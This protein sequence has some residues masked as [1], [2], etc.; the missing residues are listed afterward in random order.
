MDAI[1]PYPSA[2]SDCC[3]IFAFSFSITCAKGFSSCDSLCICE[4]FCCG[5][6]SCC[7]CGAAVSL[8]LPPFLNRSSII[9]TAEA[10]C[11]ESS[12]SSNVFGG[13]ISGAR[14]SA[15]FWIVSESSCCSSGSSGL[16][17][18][19][20]AISIISLISNGLSSLPSVAVCCAL[21]TSN[22]AFIISSIID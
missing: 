10:A 3:W 18:I 17:V 5:V 20:S 2:V 9:F 16:P 14:D 8:L 7:D 22:N 4:L 12:I 6:I 15:S 21:T 13:K 19:F 1:F 11:S